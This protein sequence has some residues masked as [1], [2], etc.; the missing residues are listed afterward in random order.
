MHARLLPS[1]H[2]LGG[3]IPDDLDLVL[4]RLH[5]VRVDANLGAH[6]R[7]Q[8]EKVVSAGRGGRGRSSVGRI[9]IDAITAM[10]VAV[11][12]LQIVAALALHA[13]AAV[14]AAAHLNV[15]G[16]VQFVLALGGHGRGQ[17]DIARLAQALAAVRRRR[18]RVAAALA[19]LAVALG[20]VA[21]DT[22]TAAMTATGSARVA[23]RLVGR[24]HQAGHNL[25]HKRLEGRQAQTSDGRRQLADGPARR[26]HI[27]P[28]KIGVLLEVLD[29]D[30]GNG[31]GKETKREN[32]HNQNLLLAL[33]VELL[34]DGNGQTED[35]NVAGNVAGGINVPLRDVGDAVA[36]EG[37]VPELGH[38]RADPDADKD[39]RQAPAANDK[40][41]DQDDAAD[42]GDGED[43]VVLGEEGQ[44]D[45]D[46]CDVVPDDG[47]VEVL[48]VE[49]VS[50]C[51]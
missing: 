12:G 1:R 43:A 17:G 3:D 38:G 39:L 21:V 11:P 34:E 45:N 44:F 47:D 29:A 27:F 51:N 23:D 36:L 15:V 7:P 35:G 25:L 28:A 16:N 46:E 10:A 19:V 9:D 6:R 18:R 37:R 24:A 41:K 40:H 20:R 8:T 2:R 5:L 13:H 33:E 22:A 49:S 4:L 30:N 42:L 31:T 48:V 26:R 32:A 50:R 14:A